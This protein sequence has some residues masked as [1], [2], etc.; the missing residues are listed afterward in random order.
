M[1]PKVFLQSGQSNVFI[2]CRTV[3]GL[4]GSRTAGVLGR[5]PV[6]SIIASRVSVW[7][8]W[9]FHANKDVFCLATW[10]DNLFSASDSLH[11]AISILEDFEMQLQ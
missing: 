10:V 1:C 5:I 7:R 2:N 6:E 3:G 4:T 11:G 9:G 8:R